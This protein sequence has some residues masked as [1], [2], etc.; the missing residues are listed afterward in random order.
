MFNI[1]FIIRF[2]LYSRSIESKSNL[3]PCSRGELF[4]EEQYKHTMNMH[5][6]CVQRKIF[7]AAR[8]GISVTL[9]KLLQTSLPPQDIKSTLDSVYE[10]GDLKATPLI[11]AAMNGHEHNVNLLISNYDP[12]IEK[13]GSIQFDG[14]LIEGATALWVASGF[15]HLNVVKTLVS[16]GADVN[17]TTWTK[18]TPLRAACFD[19]RLD[20]V[21]YLVEHGAD[22][23][24]SNEFKNT[25]L[26]I[27]AY[28]GHLNTVE[29]L[30]SIGSNPDIQARCGGTALHFSGI[31]NAFGQY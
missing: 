3:S 6:S 12:D 9:Q 11:V 28:K 27:A 22:I 26:M 18:S 5:K 24:M 31:L 30:L 23:N 21:K 1:L 14:Y 13:E 7:E 20:I 25:C 15:G 4:F 16:Y 29:Y 19:G 10:D 2:N 8:D 17:H